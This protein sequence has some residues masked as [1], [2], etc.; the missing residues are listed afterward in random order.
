MLDVSVSLGAG[1]LYIGQ[2]YPVPLN[3]VQLLG[4]SLDLALRCIA[5]VDTC[6]LDTQ[7]Q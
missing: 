1:L 7:L 3:V 6:L 2:T 4:H 5:D